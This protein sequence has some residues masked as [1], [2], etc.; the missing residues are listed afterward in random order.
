MAKKRKKEEKKKK[1]WLDL[2]PETKKGILAVLAFTLAIISVLALFGLAGQAGENLKNGLEVLF[3]QG[4]WLVPLVFLIAMVAFFRVRSRTVCLGLV[5]LCFSFLGL[6]ELFENNGGYLGFGF[7]YL[8]LKFLGFWASLIILVAFFIIAILIIFNVSLRKILL[9]FLKRKRKDELELVHEQ[10]A[11]LQTSPQEQEQEQQEQQEIKKPKLGFSRFLRAKRPAHP[12]ADIARNYMGRFPGDKGTLPKAGTQYREGDGKS[13]V[14]VGIGML[15]PFEILEEEKGQANSG[16]IKKNCQIIGQTLANFGIEVEMADVNVGPTVTQYTFR[17]SEGIKLARIT[18]LQNDLSLALAAH[19]LRIEAPIPG[20]SLVGIEIPNKKKILVRL[21]PL[22][23]NIREQGS[24]LTVALGRDVTGLPVYGSLERMPHLL[25]AGST[26]SGKTILLNGLIISLLYQNSP[27]DLKL[28]LIDPK[29]VELTAYDDIPHLLTPVITDHQR[30]INVLK[31][32]VEEMERRFQLLQEVG[33]RDILTY[34]QRHKDYLEKPMPYLVII[35][36][37]LADLMAA[38]GRDIEAAVVRLA[39]MARAVGLHLVVSTQR[40]SVE[41]IT[42]LI[43]AN[44][45]SRIAFQVASQVDSR[46]ILDLAG[47][48]KLLGNGDMLYLSSDQAKPRR[49]QG[50]FVSEQEVRKLVNYLQVEKR[51]EAIVRP[52][53]ETADKAMPGL[54]SGKERVIDDEMYEQAKELTLEIGRASASLFQ[55]RLRIGYARA[56]RLLD[57]LEEQG[58]I[59]PPEG[60]KP[61]EVLIGKEDLI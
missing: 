28:I 42:G 49:I 24:P 10:V 38:H 53:E 45:T 14:N 20:K 46:T 37:E 5:L 7:S 31:W 26:G 60:S 44:I 56:A 54:R 11:D 17:P 41:V 32:A 25:V 33:A 22:I 15:P 34:R 58:V 61:R 30:T 59:G 18:A 13:R 35:I 21:R 23:M 9:I 16:D 3:G 6:L 52:V 19:P 2:H 8:F 1:S 39:Q 50:T 47:A 51:A 27:R 48:E 55:R 29:R 12:A 4:I 40:P 57:L 36:D 43:K